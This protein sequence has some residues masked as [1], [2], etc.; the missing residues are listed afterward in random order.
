MN[1]LKKIVIEFSIF[2]A[3]GIFSGSCF[4]MNNNIHIGNTCGE[5]M[6]NKIFE[7]A[8]TDIFKNDE[9][10]EFDFDDY[11]YEETLKSEGKDKKNIFE[12]DNQKELKKEKANE[13]LKNV[14]EKEFLKK[15]RKGKKNIFEVDIPKELK[16]EK[17]NKNKNKKENK[18]SLEKLLSEKNLIKILK[19][20]LEI[21]FSKGLHELRNFN[22]KLSF[23]L[24]DFKKRFL[25]NCLL[26]NLKIEFQDFY[27]SELKKFQ[28]FK[29]LNE[30]EINIQYVGDSFRHKK[31]P[32]ALNKTSFMIN[33]PACLTIDLR[34]YFVN[35]CKKDIGNIFKRAIDRTKEYLGKISEN[36]N[37]F[38]QLMYGV[39][40][41]DL[42][43]KKEIA[44]CLSE[45]EYENMIKT[46]LE[47]MQIIYF[48]LNYYKNPE[49]YI[50][51]L[52]FSNSYSGL[53]ELND[54]GQQIYE[55]DN[56][57]LDDSRIYGK[58]IE[59]VD[60][61]KDIT[62]ELEKD[63]IY[64]EKKLKF[65]DYTEIDVLDLDGKKEAI[66][67]NLKKSM[68]DSIF[69]EKLRNLYYK[70]FFSI[71]DSKILGNIPKYF[72]FVHIR[73]II[74]KVEKNKKIRNVLYIDIPVDVLKIFDFDIFIKKIKKLLSKA[75]LE[76][77]DEVKNSSNDVLKKLKEEC[78]FRKNSI[79]E[80]EIKEKDIKGYQ[81]MVDDDSEFTKEKIKEF[82]DE[83]LKNFY[84]FIK[85]INFRSCDNK[86]N[87][88]I[89]KY[90]IDSYDIK[91]DNFK[92]NDKIINFEKLEQKN[93]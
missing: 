93:I 11:Y 65:L 92:Y 56:D 57:I 77:M 85:Y 1:R 30:E 52:I 9:E 89:I 58:E 26:E 66:K 64:E 59:I 18:T 20:P 45:K 34:N 44:K 78:L 91:R 16:K 2:L 6:E 75:L 13:N 14:H 3:Y 72:I 29:T 10:Q 8:F 70:E 76:T 49:N 61:I 43:F 21:K 22:D 19:G 53:H 39:F 71:W 28:K 67:Q 32:F 41:S 90:Q 79:Y 80:D 46:I 60:D 5:N 82:C 12:E 51:Y 7:D 37:F 15:K 40:S 33:L 74:L 17:V 73:E 42:Y 81:Q 38:V 68:V 69:R 84:E 27:N 4:A 36:K 88:K 55:Q 62:L 25:E 83:Y 47:N 54:K 48:D 86:S 35:S 87:S 23:F 50:N 31:Y 24:A 63:K